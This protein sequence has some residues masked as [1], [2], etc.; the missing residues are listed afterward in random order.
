MG[1]KR[2]EALLF[3]CECSWF[4]EHFCI[5]SISLKKERPGK[6]RVYGELEYVGQRV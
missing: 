3:I 2:V 4:Y 5:E 6:L 1:P